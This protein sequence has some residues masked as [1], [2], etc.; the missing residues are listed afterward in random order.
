[1]LTYQ[2]PVRRGMYPDPSIVRV[3]DTFYMVNSTFEYYPGVALARSKD[4][5]NWEELPGIATKP[6]QADLRHSKSNE[7]IFAATIR[8]HE[9]HF[10]VVTTN[11]AEFR[12]FILKGTLV[13]DQI[14]WEDSR[15]E[16]DVPG[17]DP[18]LFFEDGRTYLQFTGYIDDKG[19]K[20]IRQ[21]E[22]N[23]STGEILDGPKILTYG[24]GGRDVEGPHI[25]KKDGNYYLL[26]AEGGTG[27]GH[28][29]TI[30]KGPSVWGPFEDEPGVNPLFTNRD[31]AEMSLQNV[32]HSDLFTDARGNWWLTCL[33]TRPAAV[34]FSQITNIGRESLLYPV[35]WDGT[36][37]KIYNGRPEETVDLSN[38]PKHA[39]LLPTHQESSHFEDNFEKGLANGWLTLRDG[40]GD[41]LIVSNNQ[42]VLHGRTISL[43]ELGTPTFLGLRQAEHHESL[44]LTLDPDQSDLSTGSLGLM[45]VINVDHYAGVMLE[46]ANDGGVDVYRDQ[47]VADIKV[48]RLMGHLAG[49]PRTLTVT[50]TNATKVYEAVLGEQKVSFEVAA[51]NLSN[52]ALAALNTGDLQGP[53]VTNGATMVLDSVVRNPLGE[54]N[55][56]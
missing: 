2:N 44:T 4:L 11:F 20:A 26:V 19:T 27:Q 53:Y 36:W 28:M 18:D 31:R 21:V 40:L 23:L 45:T 22:I 47:Q 41:D 32:G 50:S 3:E 24:T 5:I 48:H 8:Y 43:A 7:G 33:A 46:Q 52:E 35:T 54:E 38:Y 29:I 25:L 9:G 12:T 56:G 16:V 49:L 37:P 55:D 13:G 6:E 15:V 30:F 17:I 39:E 14:K 1:M 10:Y 51:I 42:L 34:G